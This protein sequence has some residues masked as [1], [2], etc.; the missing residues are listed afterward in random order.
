M[1][2]H[3]EYRNWRVKNKFW[4][5][6]SSKHLCLVSRSVHV[7]SLVSTTVLVAKTHG[8]KQV[9][10]LL[11]LLLKRTTFLKTCQSNHYCN[12]NTSNLIPTCFFIQALFLQ[13]V[14]YDYWETAMCSKNH[15]GIKLLV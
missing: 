1:H 14:Q 11:F 4:L 13:A 15:V 3:L 12:L 9:N 5:S 6:L 10:H 7:Q 8:E 2:T